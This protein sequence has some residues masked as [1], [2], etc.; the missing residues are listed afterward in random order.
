[1]LRSRISN[2]K[3]NW[4]FNMTKFNIFEEKKLILMGKKKIGY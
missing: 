1:M 3:K 4:N 2:N